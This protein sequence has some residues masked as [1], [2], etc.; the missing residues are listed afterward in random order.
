MFLVKKHYNDLLIKCKQISR[1]VYEAGETIKRCRSD[2]GN[3]IQQ[4]F[5]KMFF[6]VSPYHNITLISFVQHVASDVLFL[7]KNVRNMMSSLVSHSVGK[8]I[9]YSF[10]LLIKFFQRALV[11]NLKCFCDQTL[12]FLDSRLSPA[13]G[14]GFS[15]W[16]QTVFD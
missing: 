10:Y 6:P 3:Y 9:K 15:F 5:A 4:M 12:I 16:V 13:Q 7:I 2:W 14:L 11:E 1:D 8:L